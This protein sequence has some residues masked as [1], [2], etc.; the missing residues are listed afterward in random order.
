[1]TNSVQLKLRYGT[2][3]EAA[4]FIGAQREV[5]VDI[6]NIRLILHDGVTAGGHALAKLAEVITNQYARVA[7]A[8]YTVLVSDRTVAVTSLS[9]ART[10][11]LPAASSF[12]TGT[13]LLIADESGNCSTTN[14]L[15]IAAAGS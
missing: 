5:T 6:D 3:A 13:Q 4:S 8:D 15:T 2:A 7:D 9:A 12:P 11:T 1:M 14:T 10:L